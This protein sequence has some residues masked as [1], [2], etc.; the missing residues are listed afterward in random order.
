MRKAVFL[1]D[2]RDYSVIACER[3]RVMLAE[4][5]L[6]TKNRETFDSEIRLQKAGL[7]EIRS[8]QREYPKALLDV[9]F[10]PDGHV[11]FIVSCQGNL[12]FQSREELA[13]APPGRFF[14]IMNQSFDYVKLCLKLYLI[15]IVSTK[16]LTMRFGAQSI[17]NQFW[18]VQSPQKPN[19]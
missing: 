15:E 19:G 12:R 11:S 8:P 2:Q 16:L 10:E 7:R 17:G 1:R 14:C 6:F 18:S 13:L 5:V 9:V 3:E 4:L